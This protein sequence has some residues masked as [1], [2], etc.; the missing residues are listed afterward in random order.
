MME[1]GIWLIWLNQRGTRKARRDYR[2][3]TAPLSLPDWLTGADA[4][5]R[6]RKYLLLEL[7]QD[8]RQP[9]TQRLG[10]LGAVQDGRD[11]LMALNVADRGP[12]NADFLGQRRMR[13]A[14]L[15]TEPGKFVNDFLNQLV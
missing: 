7:S 9:H 10:D 2:F 15:L 4:L 13:Q 5:Q 12:G 1:I 8:V 11:F 6:F 3:L 14:L